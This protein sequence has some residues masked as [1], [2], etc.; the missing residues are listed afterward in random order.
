MILTPG[1]RPTPS[2]RY[3]LMAI[4]RINEFQAKPDRA[5]ALCDFLRSVIARIIDTPG[6]RS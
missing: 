4:T 1:V 6:C 5:A 2:Y 3:V